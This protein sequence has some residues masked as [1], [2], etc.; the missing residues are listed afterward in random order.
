[1][2]GAICVDQSPLVA[3]SLAS[4]VSAGR[5]PMACHNAFSEI[6]CD[7]LGCEVTNT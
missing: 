2:H 3:G 4:T 6:G 7:S 1:M 5:R